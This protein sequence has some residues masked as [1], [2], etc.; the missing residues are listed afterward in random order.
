MTTR[1]CSP[2]GC[3]S[4]VTPFVV[5]REHPLM[6]VNPDLSAKKLKKATTKVRLQSK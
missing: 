3:W 6:V 5:T 1:D 2:P 4:E